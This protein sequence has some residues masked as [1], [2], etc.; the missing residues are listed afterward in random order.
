MRYCNV[1]FVR[2]SFKNLIQTSLADLTVDVSKIETQQAHELNS[3]AHPYGMQTN[4]FFSFL[5]NDLEEAEN[6][7]IAKEQE[8][9]KAM[10]SV[11]IMVNL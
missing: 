3:C 9:E 6:M 1:H 5:N 11:S 10:F 7:R 8:E 4:D 2:N